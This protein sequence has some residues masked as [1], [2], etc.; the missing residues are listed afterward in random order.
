MTLS[1]DDK[2][3]ILK[4]LKAAL[5]ALR[6]AHLIQVRAKETFHAAELVR[7]ISIT[8]GLIFWYEGRWPVSQC[9]ETDDGG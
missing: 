8:E 6:E 5:K 7:A 9:G 3:R 2:Q 1:D 4:S